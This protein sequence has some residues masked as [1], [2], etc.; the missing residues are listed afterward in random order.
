MHTLQ[1]K[2]IQIP[3]KAAENDWVVLCDDDNIGFANTLISD[4]YTRFQ[5]QHHARLQHVV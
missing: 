4:V 5:L 2:L 1:Y 3:M